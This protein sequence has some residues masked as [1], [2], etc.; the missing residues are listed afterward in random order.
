MKDNQEKKQ[1]TF[2]DVL[3]TPE[4]SHLHDLIH[5][6]EKTPFQDIFPKK[7]EMSMEDA[8]IREIRTLFRDNP[9]CSLKIVITRV[10]EKLPDDLSAILI[11]KMTKLIIQEWGTLSK[12]TVIEE[13]VLQAA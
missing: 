4:L 2:D 6:L 3:Q 13:R 9:N 11:L 12:A 10:L 5:Y 8:T 1:L 7:Y